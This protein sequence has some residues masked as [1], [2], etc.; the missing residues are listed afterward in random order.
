MEVKLPQPR[1]LWSWRAMTIRW[2][3]VV[4]RGRCRL[5]RLLHFAAALPRGLSSTFFYRTRRFMCAQWLSNVID[6]HGRRFE[7]SDCAMEGNKR[8]LQAKPPTR[9]SGTANPCGASRDG[10]MVGMFNSKTTTSG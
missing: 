10:A 2:T 8:Y 4:Q 7:R 6:R 3:W 1:P 5:I 9:P